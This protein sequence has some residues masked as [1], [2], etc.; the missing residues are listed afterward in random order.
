MMKSPIKACLKHH[1]VS[2]PTSSVRKTRL[3]AS[4][5]GTWV[6]RSVSI[7]SSDRL[8]P[9]S[10][11]W[12][13]LAQSLLAGLRSWL[14]PAVRLAARSLGQRPRAGGRAAMS[15]VSALAVVWVR[16]APMSAGCLS[17][18]GHQSPLSSLA[19]YLWHVSISGALSL[20]TWLVSGD[21]LSSCPWFAAR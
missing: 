10:S 20:E 21:S 14:L 17:G 4:S 16:C 19:P 8:R 13:L 9:P 3:V 7:R 5:S 11:V 12:P 1:L 18:A 6:P 15:G 2:L